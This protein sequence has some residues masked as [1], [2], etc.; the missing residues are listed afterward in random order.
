M[1]FNT[2]FEGPK[3]IIKNTFLAG[4]IAAGVVSSGDVMAQETEPI[5]KTPTKKMENAIG[6]LESDFG[7][8]E[9]SMKDLKK[10]LKSYD[11]SPGQAPLEMFLEKYGEDAVFKVASGIG[12]TYTSASLSASEFM[13]GAG[14]ASWQTFSR[15]LPNGNVEVL[16]VAFSK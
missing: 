8:E 6:S 5:N 9:V 1:N 3:K 11:R 13:K 12:Q 10:L 16:L 14:L 15:V 4:A 2:F 7:V